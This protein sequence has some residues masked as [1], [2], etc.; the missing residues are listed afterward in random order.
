MQS[1]PKILIV[2]DNRELRGL[3]CRSL[4]KDGY[5][6]A[7]AGDGKSM[8][9]QLDEARVDLVVLDIMLP[10]QDGL[11]LCRNLRAKSSI[12]VIFVSAKDDDLDK[13]L[14]LKMGADDYLTKP[15]TMAELSARIEAVLRRTEFGGVKDANDDVDGYRFDRWFFDVDRRELI[16]SGDIVVPLST[17]EYELLRIF[18]E[19][20]QR[21]MSRDQLLDLTR[22]RDA[23]VFDRSVDTQISRLRRKI[24][25]DSR[26]PQIIK[27][28]WGGGYVFAVDVS[29]S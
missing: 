4:K 21:V 14:G 9:R 5:R 23:T 18:V 13:V 11:T 1:V 28:V 29:S 24:E 16:E 6:V 10:G 3:I 26:H 25:A 17:S 20:P 12:P 15:F 8:Q 19:R 7:E 2:E 22:G 27:T